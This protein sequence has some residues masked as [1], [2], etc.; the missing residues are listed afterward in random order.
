[1]VEPPSFLRWLLSPFVSRVSS[2]SAIDC[3]HDLLRCAIAAIISWFRDHVGLQL[4]P[5]P[6]AGRGR[7]STRAVQDAFGRRSSERGHEVRPV[8]IGTGGNGISRAALRALH[9]MANTGGHGR[10]LVASKIDRLPDQ[11]WTFADASR[12]LLDASGP[13]SPMIQRCTSEGPGKRSMVRKRLVCSGRS[14]I[15]RSRR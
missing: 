1:M 8:A 6:P 7:P 10:A 4:T 15:I 9:A 11:C 5:H 13:C 14:T 12:D 3:G 2:H